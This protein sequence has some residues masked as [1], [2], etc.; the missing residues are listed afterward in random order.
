MLRRFVHIPLRRCFRTT[1][2]PPRTLNVFSLAIASTIAAATTCVTYQLVSDSRVISLDSNTSLSREET[3]DNHTTRWQTHSQAVDESLSRSPQEPTQQNTDL[4]HHNG[5][6][7]TAGSA[8][9]T[10]RD[11]GGSGGGAYNP[12]T[13]EINWDCPCLGGMAHGPCGQQFREAF[14]CFVFSEEEPK[15]INCVDKFKAMQNCFREHPE[16][17]RDEILDEDEEDT[18]KAPTVVASSEVP[19]AEPQVP[20]QKRP[21]L[22]Q[23]SANRQEFDDAS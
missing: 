18:E 4:A 13:G 23:T 19:N 12:T 1:T 21:P 16:V 3:D 7:H 17:Y 15:G 11:D 14:S 22:T 6:S 10:I 9:E 5:D 20:L 8:D 2:P